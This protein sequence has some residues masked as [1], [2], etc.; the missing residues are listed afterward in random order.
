M[1]LY[2]T[3]S[4]LLIISSIF[5]IYTTNATT[6]SIW[7]P[8]SK[9]ASYVFLRPNISLASH[10]NLN[11]EKNNAVISTLNIKVSASQ[12]VVPNDGQQRLLAAYRL[13]VNSI[14]V[15]QGPGRGE[16][17]TFATTTKGNAIYDVVTVTSKDILGNGD[18]L[19][20]ALQC[21]QGDGGTDAWAQL[22]VEAFNTNK[23]SLG[24]YQTN[25]NDWVGYNA[26]EIFE[27]GLPDKCGRINE[28]IRADIFSKNAMWK[29]NTFV[30]THSKGWMKVEG[31]T[32]PIE[33]IAKATKPLVVKS[34]IEPKYVHQIDGLTYFFDFGYEQMS[35]IQLM[36]PGKGQNLEGFKVEIRL[37]EE[38]NGTDKILF[39]DTSGNKYISNCTLANNGEDSIIEYHEYPGLWRYGTLKFFPKDKFIKFKND[40]NIEFTVK[41]WAVQYPFNDDDSSFTSSSDM[42][43]KV[44]TLMKDS[45][46][47]TSLDTFTDSNTRERLPYEA[48]GYITARSRWVLQEEYEWPK[49]SIKHVLH[50]PTWPTEWKQ[51]T[52]LLAHEHYMMTGDNS[53]VEEYF[54]LLKNNTMHPFIHPDTNLVDFTGKIVSHRFNSLCHSTIDYF[55][56]N[57][58]DG[59]TSCDIVDWEESYRCG[60]NFT[61]KNT[62]VNAFAYKSM[63]ML[64]ELAMLVPALVNEAKLLKTQAVNTKQAIL[65]LMYNKKTGF[66][67]DGL[68]SET[69]NPGTF[70]AQHYPLWLGVTPDEDVEIVHK[71][72]S[73]Q[74]M[75]GS[76]YSSH[77][78]LYGLYERTAS[79][80]NG[81]LGLDLMVQCS[82]QSWCN[83]IESGATT[84]WEMWNFYQG[85]HSHPWSSTPAS[86]IVFGL[87]GLRPTVPGWS[88]WRVKIASGNLKFGKIKTPTPNGPIVQN[89]T[90]NDNGTFIFHLIQ[91]PKGTIAEEICLPNFH[92]SLKK[93]NILNV[94]NN[95]DMIHN[96]VNDVVYMYVN[97][98]KIKARYENLKYKTYV[99]IDNIKESGVF[100]L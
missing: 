75:R 13:F 43:N 36:V 50:N 46:R 2:K 70:H 67:C 3:I 10:F 74:G 57:V 72:L 84:S 37:S 71:Y 51:F 32:P 7:L 14:E 34:G 80:D 89:F 77:S 64:S 79:I 20:L 99:C 65:K 23:E 28:N 92:T 91:I 61:T 18:T 11:K 15:T 87:F 30:P 29:E 47:L 27:K 82:N 39:P 22:E 88:R 6:P 97:G 19:G 96:D 48:D 95:I 53:I 78:L 42:L 16:V 52:I 66:F 54:H 93:K 49:H 5:L 55:P 44:W 33:P 21:F 8:E 58:T 86:V 12:D 40:N 24:I 38:V 62:V 9:H 60:Y 25:V 41:R 76:T 17:P 26:D 68:C 31:R 45:L 85:T 98:K 83:M 69:A 63:K 59:G 94:H 81:Q 73:S 1:T 100:V 56:P 90:K 4:I 35:G